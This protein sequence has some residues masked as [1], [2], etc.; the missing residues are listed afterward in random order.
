MGCHAAFNALT[1][2]RDAAAANPDA[3]VLVC[4]V[5]LCSLHFA[6]G[7]DPGKL[8][9]N[10][11]FADGAA[12]AVIG[13]GVGDG[14]GSW[15][16]SDFSSCLLAESGDA[17]TWNI[18]DHGFE[19]TLSAGVPEIIRRQLLPWCKAWLARHELDFSDI[20]GWAIHPGGPKI[21]AATAEALT[22]GP[23]DLR[24]SR[25]VLAH[26]GNMSSATVLF[27][28]RQMTGKVS[29]P[30]VAIGLGPGLV[31]EGMLLNR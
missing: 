19:M 28:L 23:E 30:C 26:H 25:Q 24:F 9:A 27:I 16:L 3:R 5:E 13:P 31:A 10:A 7:I 2:A 14:D 21:L 4:C 11:L 15:Q 18:G 20:A 22:L 12:A 17:M 29:G 6:Y 8:V 1:A